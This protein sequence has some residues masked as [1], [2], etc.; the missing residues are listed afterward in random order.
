MRIFIFLI[1][2]K[3]T[4]VLL[5]LAKIVRRIIQAD[6]DTKNFTKVEETRSENLIVANIVALKY[7]DEWV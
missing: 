3:Y 1:Q 7:V 6:R 2:P 5:E 4:H